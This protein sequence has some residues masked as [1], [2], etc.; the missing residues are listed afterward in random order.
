MPHEDFAALDRLLV[1]VV[2]RIALVERLTIGGTALTLPESFL[3]RE[4]DR[5]GELSQQ[6]LAERLWMDKSRISRVATALEHSGW[7][8]RHRD[9]A[10]RRQYKVR[11]T[12]EGKK[13]ATRMVQTVRQHHVELFK[14][15]T[16]QERSALERGLK[17]LHRGFDAGAFDAIHDKR[18]K[19]PR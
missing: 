19:P 15:M 2:R 4:L 1:A 12:K 10:N 9:H 11:L 17:A 7:V 14:A 16:V 13:L 8:E 3:I 6:E 5:Q 18:S